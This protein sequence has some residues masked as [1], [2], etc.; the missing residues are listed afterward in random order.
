VSP[1]GE[2]TAWRLLR[3][4]PAGGTEGDGSLRVRVPPVESTGDEAWLEVRGSGRWK[5]SS[6]P[7]E[8]ARDLLDLFLPL[9]L[10]SEVVVAQL[11]QSLD[12]RI[13][14]ESGHSHYVTGPEDIQRLHRL[15]ALMDAVL[16]GAGTVLSDDPR[17]TVR[18]VSGDDP[19]RVV[20]DPE[21]RIDPAHRVFTD[22]GGRTVVI[23][24]EG[25]KASGSF[26]SHGNNVET[27]A[28]PHAPSHGFDPRVVV[29]ALREQ[30]MRRILVEGGGVTVSRFLD[31]GALDRLHITVAPMIIGSGIPALTL[32]PVETLDDALRP[33]CRHFHLG[34]DILFDLDLRR[35]GIHGEALP[36]QEEPN[37]DGGSGKGGGQDQ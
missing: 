13:A 23:K 10:G 15:R 37:E 5:A 36:G 35:D 2:E 26:P 14:T 17:L 9:L 6:A 28:L 29:R 34:S 7:T 8:D 11:A 30:G 21:G 31:A 19:V 1:L 16:V 27:L 4:L 18:E 33:T 12:G 24:R 22:G 32:P 3:A 25:G 20:L